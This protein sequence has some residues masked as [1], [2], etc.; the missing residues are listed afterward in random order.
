M[1]V[2][3]LKAFLNENGVK[4]VMISH[5]PA[6]TAQEIAA[7]AKIPGMEL[8]KT[9][10]VRLDGEMA[11][12]VLPASRQVDL[13]KLA[14]LSGAEVAELA[15][16]DEFKGLFPDCEPGA[17]PPFGNLYGMPVYVA[18]ALSEDEEIAFNAGTHT[19][20]MQLRYQ[21]FEKL[22]QPKVL[23]FSVQAVPN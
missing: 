2:Q 18:G 6:Y 1:P 11:M 17:M 16:E 7:S 19:E 23:D 5:S 20:L 3:K 4:Y 13:D 8:A 22:V 10:M 14:E 15:T 9:V 21:D 12:A